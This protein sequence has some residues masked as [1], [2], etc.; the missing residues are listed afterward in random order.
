MS[1][2]PSQNSPTSNNTYGLNLD[3]CTNGLNNYSNTLP[4]TT[5][6]STNHLNSFYGHEDDILTVNNDIFPENPPT[7]TSNNNHQQ[8]MLNN[9]TTSQYI[10]QTPPQ[11]AFSP[12]H[13]Y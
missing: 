3:G 9:A 1:N 8:H 7:M 4:P 10:D 5:S 11:N 12:I 13:S 2:N 6:Q